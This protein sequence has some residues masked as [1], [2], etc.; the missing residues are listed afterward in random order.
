MDNRQSTKKSFV[1]IVSIILVSLVLVLAVGCESKSQPVPQ[2]TQ[3]VP[4]GEPAPFDGPAET[5]VVNADDSM[6]N[7][8]EESQPVPTTSSAP[9]P[10]ATTFLITGENFKFVMDG[11]DAPE[12]R[13]K[14]GDTV[15]IEFSSTDGFHDWVVDE[16]DAHTQKVRPGTPTSVEFVASKKGTFEYYCSVGSHRQQGMKGKLIVE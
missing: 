15:R 3:P 8:E 16:F 10:G 9:T 13:V 2:V 14:E 5:N 7:M 4:Y 1:N 6:E 12:L 11:K